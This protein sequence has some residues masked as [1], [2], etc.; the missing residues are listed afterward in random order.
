MTIATDTHATIEEL[1]EVVFSVWSMQ[2]LIRMPAGQ[3]REPAGRQT[4]SELEV[5]AS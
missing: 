5:S 1:M 4:I 3:T 2:R